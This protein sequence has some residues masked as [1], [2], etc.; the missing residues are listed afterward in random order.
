MEEPLTSDDDGARSTSSVL[1][2]T[3][4]T[5]LVNSSQTRKR[6]AD[7]DL[8][9]GPSKRRRSFEDVHQY[10]QLLE[11]TIQEVTAGHSFH[12]ED[13]PLAPSQVGA[14][15][16]TAQ[17]KNEFF[18]ATTV[19]GKDDI[20]GVAARVKTKSAF[21]VVSYKRLLQ[22]GLAEL[23]VSEDCYKLVEYFELPAAQELSDDCCQ[24]LD[25]AAASLRKL[26]QRGEQSSAEQEWSNLWLLTPEVAKKIES[27][28]ADKEE[29]QRVAAKLPAA[30]LLKLESWLTLAREVFMNPG[31]PRVDDNWQTVATPNDDGE[32]KLPSIYYDAFQ[33]FANLAVSVTERLVQATL[34][35]AMSR[36]RAMHSKHFT[37]PEGFSVQADDVWGACD[38]LKLQC[39]S[40]SFWTYAPRRCGLCVYRK[41]THRANEV[42]R[43][44]PEEVEKE[45]GGKPITEARRLARRDDALGQSGLEDGAESLSAVSGGEEGSS[46]TSSDSEEVEPEPENENS[47]TG[48]DGRLTQAITSVDSTSSRNSICLTDSDSS[49]RPHTASD[50]IDQ[51]W[52]LAQEQETYMEMLERR[53]TVG[54]AQPRRPITSVAGASGASSSSGFF[55]SSPRSS[56]GFGT[57]LSL[58]TS[59]SLQ[60]G[61]TPSSA[62]SSTGTNVGEKTRTQNQGRVPLPS[63]PPPRQPEHPANIVDWRARTEYRAEWETLERPSVQHPA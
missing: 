47:P 31:P 14:S 23:S 43:M 36:C 56:S 19:L 39:N 16:W 29:G 13:S 26:E 17:E 33:D 54:M 62:I 6:D 61:S 50:L 21:E 53:S 5:D 44:S 3:I 49:Y 42:E 22:Q 10:R 58:S 12:D 46:S 25:Q 1:S 18:K 57:T 8:Q 7:E 28:L 2:E 38:L 52:Q 34:F 30:E 15:S 51:Q 37:D 63:K 9:T 59:A 24:Q 4:D 32:L 35:Q 60:V 27:K 45:L 41:V 11:E 55:S 20:R 48:D 40:Q